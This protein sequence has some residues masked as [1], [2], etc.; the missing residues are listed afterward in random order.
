[1]SYRTGADTIFKT[2]IYDVAAVPGY[3]AFPSRSNAVRSVPRLRTALL[4]IAER[5]S[6]DTPMTGVADHGMLVAYRTW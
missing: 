2:R 4:R 3:G 6:R 1:M 5:I